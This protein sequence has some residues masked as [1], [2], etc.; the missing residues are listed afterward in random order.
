MKMINSPQNYPF[1][2][3]NNRL[4]Q[5]LTH[6]ITTN[7]LIIGGGMTGLMAAQAFAQRGLHVTLLEKSFCGGGATGKS[8]GF[9]TPA[10]ELSLDDLIAFYDHDNGQKLWEFACSGVELIRKT[11]N[12]YSLSCDYQEQDTLIVANSRSDFAN[13]IEPEHSRRLSLGYPSNLY[14][15]KTV[16]TIL[17]SSAYDGGVSY[18]GSFGINAYLYCR[19]L[20]KEL[21]KQGVE[22]YEDSPAVKIYAQ[23]TETP[24][25]SVRADH[26]II[27]LD[28]FTPALG[29]LQKDIYHAQTFLMLSSPL[30]S[31]EV[32]QL[33]P[34]RPYMVWDTDLIYQ[35]YRLTGD[36]RLMV[37]GATLLYTY[38]S[39][40]Q[41]HST[42]M[43]N[44]LNSYIKT[45]FPEL[46]ISFP[47][48]WPGLIGITK[49]IV[50]IV[51]NDRTQPGLSYACAGAGLPWSAAAG[52]YIADVVLDKRDDFNEF[53][54]PYRKFA[55]GK[56]P[57]FFIGTKAS[58]A[59]SN[60]LRI[61]KIA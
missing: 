40:E 24:L 1:W 57:Q 31:T 36:N 37:G 20:K 18:P 4:Y 45:K 7:I 8:S 58:F 28:R 17:N 14:T 16:P 25:G 42:Y 55:V 52:N 27:C 19:D 3:L 56:I 38:A 49:D 33:F 30:S 53:F 54:S 29:Y 41:Y 12:R 10:S 61:K 5:P 35:Y 26:T 51:G 59:L 21:E 60:I 13:Q 44:K 48:M 22:I 9:I 6:S 47:Y 50:P 2:Y 32:K 11:I 15:A 34:E 46:K 23:E 43:V 39:Y